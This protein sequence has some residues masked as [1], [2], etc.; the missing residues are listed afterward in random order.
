MKKNKDIDELQML[1]EL[2]QSVEESEAH[3]KFNKFTDEEKVMIRGM[4]NI[5]TKY[6]NRISLL[7]FIFIFARIVNVL[8]VIFLVLL[9]AKIFPYY[10]VVII[11]LL[12]NPVLSIIF[13][14]L[15]YKNHNNMQ[16][17]KQI[18]EPYGLTLDDLADFVINLDET[19]DDVTSEQD[20]NS[21]TSEE[22][23]E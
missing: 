11:L 20:D 5:F 18:A 22:N 10:I 4:C 7:N 21:N 2:E 3:E 12:L 13:K 23:N 19:Y 1:L 16:R 17:L 15:L 8:S 6:V 9:F 14:L